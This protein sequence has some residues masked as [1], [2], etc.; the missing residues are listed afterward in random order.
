MAVR[1][2]RSKRNARLNAKQP[3]ARASVALQA[4]AMVVA[5]ASANID[6]TCRD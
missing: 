3:T 2:A 5:E 1:R 4:V 6:M